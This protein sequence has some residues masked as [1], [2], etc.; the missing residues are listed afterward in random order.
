MSTTAEHLTDQKK[1]IRVA[2]VRYYLDRRTLEAH[3]TSLLDAAHLE[4]A[5]GLRAGAPVFA[6]L[7]RQAAEQ[8]SDHCCRR[9]LDKQRVEA[10][11]CE[12]GMNSRPSTPRAI[13]PNTVSITY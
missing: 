9:E 11:L 3:L 10:A 4:Q 8:V 1:H 13:Q 2:A 6:V 7:N 5:R 12:I